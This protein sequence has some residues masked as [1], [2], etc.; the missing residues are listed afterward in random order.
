V[1]KASTPPARGQQAF[2]EDPPDP[3]RGDPAAEAREVLLRC[4]A[5]TEAAVA[6]VDAAVDSMREAWASLR[7]AEARERLARRALEEM[8]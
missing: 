1:K 8:R 5:S 6:R 7:A 4:E 2:P 3:A